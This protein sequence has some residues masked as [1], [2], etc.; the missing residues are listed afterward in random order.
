MELPFT[1][2]MGFA[3]YFIYQGYADRLGC[4][5]LQSRWSA[6]CN[7]R[8]GAHS[9]L[10]FFLNSLNFYQS[11]SKR[12]KFHV[13]F[14]R[15][16]RKHFPKPNIVCCI[17]TCGHC[18]SKKSQP[19]C[20]LASLLVYFLVMHATYSIRPPIFHNVWEHIVGITRY[21]ITIHSFIV[22]SVLP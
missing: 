21:F 1:D 20:Y 15:L 13:C 12:G 2:P 11:I 22:R 19:Y 8:T 3:W 17:E 6:T 5:A 18:T 14:Y 16:M 10:A 9:H 7:S 4:R